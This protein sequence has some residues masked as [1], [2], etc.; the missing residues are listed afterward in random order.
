MPDAPRILIISQVYVPDPTSVGQHMADAAADLATRGYDVRVLT[1]GR[2]YTDPS[3]RYPP[4]EF[5]DGVEVVRLPWSSLGKK[6]IAHRVLGQLIF[7]TQVALRGVFT[8][9]LR[10][11]VVS[12]S[13]P[14]ASIAALCIRFFRRV[15]MKFWAMD[16]NPD[17]V[18]AMGVYKESSL[19]VRA[20]N[21]L[22]RRLLKACSDVVALDRFMADRLDAKTPVLQKTAIIPPWPQAS[23]SED[24]PRETN[25]FIREHGLQDK[26]VVMYSG[27]HGALL[28]LDTLLNASLALRDD[29]RIVFMFIGGGVR[30]KE[31]EEFIAEHDPPNVRSLPYQPFDQIKYSLSAADVHAVTMTDNMV[32]IIHPCKIYGALEVGRPVLF[33][34]P[35]PSHVTDLLNRYGCGW[36]IAHGDVNGAVG[37]IRQAADDPEA[38]RAKGRRARAGMEEGVD[39]RML[40]DQFCD[41]MVRG[42]AQP[43]ET[44]AMSDARSPAQTA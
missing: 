2:G 36:R 16:L 35:E 8:R 20:F 27:N 32:G 3:V 41:V 31:V 44:A 38:T 13:P 22:N 26:F 14:M 23:I 42:L 30:K 17:Q 1:S 9:R 19:P 11:I 7:L 29:P 5:I 24:V 21:W 43:S 25:P 34:G 6:T 15:P 28:P 37:I 39:P 12:T 18:V 10:G 4:H 33:V 40:R